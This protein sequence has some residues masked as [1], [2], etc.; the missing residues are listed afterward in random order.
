MGLADDLCGAREELSIPV[1]RSGNMQA[2]FPALPCNTP[3]CQE[4]ADRYTQEAC[5][6]F[7]V[8]KALVSQGALPGV[9]STF[10]SHLQTLHETRA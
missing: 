8:C 6:L 9:S 4:V 7:T 1:S 10:S 3:Q 2:A 5:R